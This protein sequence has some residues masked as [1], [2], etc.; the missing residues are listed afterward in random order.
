MERRGAACTKG[1]PTGGT[2]GGRVAAGAR[3]VPKWMYPF[4]TSLTVDLLGAMHLRRVRAARRSWSLRSAAK[5]P[6]A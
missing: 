1:L 6:A 5:F 2:A 3:R 4:R